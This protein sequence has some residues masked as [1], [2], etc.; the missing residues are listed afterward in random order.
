MRRATGTKCSPGWQSENKFP[1]NIRRRQLAGY[2]EVVTMQAT[3][4]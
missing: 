3:Q 4:E 1:E 2:D